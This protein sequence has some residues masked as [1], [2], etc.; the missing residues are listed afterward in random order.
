MADAK[1]PS[2]SNCPQIAL[3]A[4]CGA[5]PA[6]RRVLTVIFSVTGLVMLFVGCI[7]MLV[8]GIGMYEVPAED[9]CKVMGY[10]GHPDCT[11]T[12]QYFGS[13]CLTKNKDD[14]NPKWAFAANTNGVN[15]FA[16]VVFS[17]RDM[18]ESFKTYYK[19]IDSSKISQYETFGI[20]FDPLQPLPTATYSN[21][22]F[23]AV[24]SDA[25]KLSQVF[26]AVATI[27]YRFRDYATAHIPAILAGS[28]TMAYTLFALL[29][30]T[31]FSRKG[32]AI[33]N[34]AFGA[35][36]MALVVLA[37]RSALGSMFAIFEFFNFVPCKNFNSA[38]FQNNGGKL[39]GLY[40]CY[41]Q[42]C[43]GNKCTMELN[44]MFGWTKGMLHLV[45][46]G[47]IV[48]VVGFILVGGLIAN[49]GEFFSTDEEFVGNA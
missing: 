31:C 33:Y 19:N 37:M 21:D 10:S 11:S 5:N 4:A 2:G 23:S 43:V 13:C 30:L 16:A 49:I 44:P 3:P 24:N 47:G 6:I 45:Y 8:G 40:P 34:L 35:G 28:F 36:V 9:L 29:N 18:F 25:N 41:D 12:E 26:T 1:T 48:S 42:K 22:F 7:M 15:G 20:G 46:S 38:L 27:P 32:F 17:I 39:Y 14:N